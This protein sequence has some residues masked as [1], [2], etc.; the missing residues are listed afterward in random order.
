[1]PLFWIS[2][3]PFWDA[4]LYTATAHYTI[5]AAATAAA[6]RIVGVVTRLL[7][8][9][10][11]LFFNSVTELKETPKRPDTTFIVESRKEEPEKAHFT[12]SS[13]D[14]TPH[15]VFKEGQTFEV[16]EETAKALHDENSDSSKPENAKGCL[17]SST[18]STEDIVAVDMLT[19]QTG[20][21]NM[22]RMYVFAR[23]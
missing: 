22:Y 17:L 11:K 16:I 3:S 15:R 23:D 6:V 18:A 7:K 10:T 20:I 5:V 12:R 14:K 21:S 4:A 9:V 2:R 1:M 8:L 13:G 19:H